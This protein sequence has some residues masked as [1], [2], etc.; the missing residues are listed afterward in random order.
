MHVELCK[1]FIFLYNQKMYVQLNIL[2]N[3]INSSALSKSMQY[4]VY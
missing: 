1:I 3:L 4:D 2:S